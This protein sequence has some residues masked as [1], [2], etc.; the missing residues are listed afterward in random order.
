LFWGALSW[1][2]ER[3]VEIIEEDEQTLGFCFLLFC[4]ERNKQK[5]FG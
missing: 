1:E 4:G 2:E 3:K 5:R